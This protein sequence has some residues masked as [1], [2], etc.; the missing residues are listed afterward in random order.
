MKFIPN[1]PLRIFL[2]HSSKDKPS[3]RQL[4]K[5]LIR[6]GFN[7]WLDEED[8]LPGQDWDREITKAVK[9]SD[10]VLICLSHDSI[11]KSGYVQ[12]EIRFS[13]NVAEEKPDGV[14]FI[15]PVRLEDCEVPDKLK[16]WQWVD[17]Y[18]ENGYDRLSLS[19]KNVLLNKEK[20]DDYAEAMGTRIQS[21]LSNTSM[22][23]LYVPLSPQLFDQPPQQLTLLIKPTGSREHDKRRIKTIHGTLVSFHGRDKFSFQIFENGKGHLIDFPNETTRICKELLAR[24][25]HLS[26]SEN[27]LRFETL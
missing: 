17:L 21:G 25:K 14:I 4:Y 15:I 11:T 8:I 19:L 23:S 6:D 20:T 27:D 12:K 10:I 22:P 16:K 2:C 1:F 7:V 18:K 3:V 26:I 9:L 24:L 5:Y 13:L